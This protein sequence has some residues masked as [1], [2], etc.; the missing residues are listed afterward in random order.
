MPLLLGS[1][2]VIEL[3]LDSTQKTRNLIES[4]LNLTKPF[5][6]ESC[7][8]QVMIFF[9]VDYPERLATRIRQAQD[10]THN[11]SHLTGPAAYAFLLSWVVGGEYRIAKQ[12]YKIAMFNDNHILGRFKDQWNSFLAESSNE[13]NP[14][15]E[16][17]LQEAASSAAKNHSNKNNRLKKDYIQVI[18]TL[19]QDAHAV[20]KNI[21]LGLYGRNDELRAT[22]DIIITNITWS[23]TKNFPVLYEAI[24]QNN[25][26]EYLVAFLKKESEKLNIQMEKYEIDS[27]AYKGIAA[28]LAL[29]TQQIQELDDHKKP[30]DNKLT[31]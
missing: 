24:H 10:L 25:Y 19:L 15:S 8:R 17:N 4:L 14:N 5:R 6:P 3:Q 26:Q 27:P 28:R 29:Y 7:A 16:P 12:G 13:E 1:L 9:H 23:H 18:D 11:A 20:R 21:E 2:Q 31:P 30:Q 22:L